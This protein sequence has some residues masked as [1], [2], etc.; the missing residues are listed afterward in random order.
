MSDRRYVP[1]AEVARPHGVRGELRLRLWNPSSDLLLRRPPIRLR[2]P[3]GTTRE[4]SI[5]RARA[6]NKGIL[7]E[8]AGVDD[9]DAAEALRG[10][11]VLVPRDVFPE[12][13]SGEFY[14]CDLEGAKAVL[15]ATGEEIG[16]VTAV[17]SYPTCDA[18]VIAR[19]DGGTIEVPLVEAF[20]ASVDVAGAVVQIVTLDGIEP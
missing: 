6:A 16:R 9:R 15:A 7:V 13:S 3:D 1:V 19:G 14:V 18:L 8:L 20:V 12:A 5:K 17:Q 2:M 11:D 4:A 10:A